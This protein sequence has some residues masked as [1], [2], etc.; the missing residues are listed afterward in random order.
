MNN[1]DRLVKIIKSLLVLLK[2]TKYLFHLIRSQPLT[3]NSRESTC[4]MYIIT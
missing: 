4:W 3:I 2:D 1:S